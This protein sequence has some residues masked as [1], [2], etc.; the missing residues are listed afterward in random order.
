MKSKQNSA[1]DFLFLGILIPVTDLHLAAHDF[2]K[3][4][5][6]Q[7]SKEVVFLIIQRHVLNQIQS[8]CT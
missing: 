8:K 7:Q 6:C 2:A 5:F 4:N 3:C 1:I